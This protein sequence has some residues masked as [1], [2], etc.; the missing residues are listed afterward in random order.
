MCGT[1]ATFE[2]H[3]PDGTSVPAANL[4]EAN[5]LLRTHQR[6]WPNEDLSISVAPKALIAPFP[7]LLQRRKPMSKRATKADWIHEL[8]VMRQRIEVGLDFWDA[9]RASRLGSHYARSTSDWGWNVEPLVSISDWIRHN[10]G[11]RAAF[12]MIDKSIAAL[13][14]P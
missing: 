1:P 9:V 11:K 12:A 4:N 2:I 13:E 10:G 7:E 8:R 5:S 3:L 6:Q 14:S